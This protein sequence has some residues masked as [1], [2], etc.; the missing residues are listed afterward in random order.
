MLYP[1]QTFVATA[2][3][4][5]RDAPYPL[6]RNYGTSSRLHVVLATLLT[7]LQFDFIYRTDCVVTSWWDRKA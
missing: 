7:T 3:L 4:S 6:S 5:I 1:N 2:V